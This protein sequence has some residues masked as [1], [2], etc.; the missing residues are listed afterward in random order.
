M[1]IQ[2]GVGARFLVDEYNLSGGVGSLQRLYMEVGQFVTTTVQDGGM[3]RTP[4]TRHGAIDFQA[5][6]DDAAGGTHPVLSTVPT[7]D[8]IVSYLHRATRG[9]PAWAEVAKQTS[10]VPG[11]GPNGELKID[12]ATVANGYGLELGHTLTA[13]VENSTGTESLAGVDDTETAASTSF[14]LQAFLHVTAFTG[15]SVDIVIQ[16]S[17][18]DAATDP[19]VDLTGGSFTTVSAVGS[20]R[21]Q[22]GRAQT[23]KRWLRV[24]LS[25]TYSDLDFTVV[26]IRNPTTVNF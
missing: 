20:E 24:D 2:S 23:V 14:G 8:R 4:T 13:G 25:G 18:D 5:F 11:L 22:T 16:D 9:A 6:F 3:R 10:Y 7:A 17:D 19:Y 15:T 21:I 12:V 1:T 26:V